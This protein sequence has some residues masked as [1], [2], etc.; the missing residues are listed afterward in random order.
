MRQ[1]LRFGFILG[2]ICIVAVG[3]LAGINTLTEPK[4]VA[5][6]EAEIKATLLE[7][8]PEGVKFKPV[9]LNQE[10]IY[11]VYD[12]DN[13]FLGIVFKAE[14]RGYSSK[15]ETMAGMLKSGEIRAIK[16]LSQN[17]TPGLGSRI[18]EVEEENTIWDVLRGRKKEKTKK[19][20][21]QEQ[22]KNKR[23][24]QLK[25][26]QAITGATISSKAVIDSVNKKAQELKKIIENGR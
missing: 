12:K 17:E 6:K 26:I 24:D 3:L 10:T 19:P 18:A 14:G 20:W 11:K 25:D 23:I 9:E 2:L 1:M 5:R 13:N 16:I 7:L 21:F 15:I 22:F 4:I 8:F